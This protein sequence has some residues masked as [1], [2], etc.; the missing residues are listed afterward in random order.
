M[1]AVHRRRIRMRRK[2]PLGQLLLLHSAML[3]KCAYTATP[4]TPVESH[5]DPRWLHRIQKHSSEV[6]YEKGEGWLRP[7]FCSRRFLSWDRLDRGD[8]FFLGATAST[9]P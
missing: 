3:S 4:I 2:W 1:A 6:L 7:R 9:L 8:Y 5:A